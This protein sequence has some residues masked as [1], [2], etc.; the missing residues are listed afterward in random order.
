MHLIANRSALVEV[1]TAASSIASSRTPKEVLRCVCLAAGDDHLLI[2]ATDQEVGL[3][4]T[5]RQVEVKKTGRT[6]VSAEKLLQIMRESVDETLVLETDD[7][8]CHIRGSDSHFEIFT[9][10]VED[11]PPVPD[12]EDTPD[13]EIEAEAL[14][15][16]LARTAFA[17]AKENTR[18]AINGILWEKGNKKLSLVAT[19]GR[20]LAWATA[21]VDKLHG[22]DVKA[23][24]PAKAVGVLQRILGNAEGPVAVQL[25][26]NQV[27]VRG[28][29]Y[30]VSSSLVEGHFP[31]YQ[32]VVPKDGDRKAELTTEVFRSAVRRAALLT[33]EQSKGVCL[34]F[35]PGKLVL[36]SRAPEQG[37]ATISLA[38][39]YS[40]AEFEIGFSP[41]FLEDALR[42]VGTPTV[43]MELK[44]GERPGVMRAGQNFTY[45]LMPVSLK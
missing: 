32:D 41:V 31:N 44:D 43:T 42:V 14:L 28:G 40:A 45:V 4:G 33:N 8:K 29:D 27:V 21:A 17:V 34:G 39:D 26:P 6:L 25:R 30:V 1:L 24:V 20:R 16:A 3:R 9:Q 10:D 36:S 22:A 18:Y 13:F 38:I 37:E 11:F 12:V 35:A 7:S 5:I 23:I 19:D 2:S 15:A